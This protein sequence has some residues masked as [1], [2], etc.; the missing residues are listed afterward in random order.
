VPTGS[1]HGVVRDAIPVNHQAPVAGARVAVTYTAGSGP[2]TVTAADGTYR[3]D[4]VI[5][6]QTFTVTVSRSGYQ[7][8]ARSIML[9]ADDVSTDIQLMPIIV[10]VPGVVMDAASDATPI[11]SAVIKILNGPWGEQWFAT[12]AVGEFR[13]QSVW[14][15]FDISVSRAGFETAMAH[16]DALAPGRVVVR[17]T[18]QAGRA[19]AAFTG[20]LCTTERLPPWLNC[21]APFTRTHM[22]DVG[23]PGSLTLTVNYA[24]VGDYYGNSLTLDIRCGSRVVAEKKLLKGG[25]APPTVVPDNIVGTFAVPVDQA[26]S[27]DLRLR[28]FIADTKGGSQTTYRVDVEYPR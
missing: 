16:V 8:V 26:C 18:R 22:I 5:G 1:L 12:D 20:A 23:H 9:P 10:N 7:T 27:Y 28:D 25:Y 21:S 6:G 11:E 17:L 2:S 14:G 13:L 19:V 4:G 15:E 24:Y 3:L